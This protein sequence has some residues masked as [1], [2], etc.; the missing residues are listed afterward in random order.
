[1]PVGSATKLLPV[2]VESVPVAVREDR[3]PDLGRSFEISHLASEKRS[4]SCCHTTLVPCRKTRPGVFDPAEAKFIAFCF[5]TS[6]MLSCYIG[7]LQG[8]RLVCWEIHS[9][10]FLRLGHNAPLRWAS[11]LVFLQFRATKL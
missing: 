1:M 7:A 8:P 6:F 5:I 11:I 9:L 2:P 3:Q 4:W 10:S